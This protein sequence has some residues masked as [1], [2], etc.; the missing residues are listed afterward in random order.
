MR[1]SENISDANLDVLHY[2]IRD[3]TH[4][5]RKAFV[6]HLIGGLAGYI[7]QDRWVRLVIA[8]RE[9]ATREDQ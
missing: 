7:H 3:L 2:A 4:Q 1:Y 5:Q 9:F 6:D 8:A